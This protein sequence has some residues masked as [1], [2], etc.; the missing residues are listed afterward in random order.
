MQ[1]QPHLPSD[2]TSAA[3][4]DALLRGMPEAFCNTGGTRTGDHRPVRAEL[5]EGGK[6]YSILAATAAPLAAQ[7]TEPSSVFRG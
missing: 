6:H 1:T 5:P 3:L 2:Q 4:E 7:G